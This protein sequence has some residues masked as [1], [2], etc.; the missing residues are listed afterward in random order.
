MSDKP[1]CMFLFSNSG[2]NSIFSEQMRERLSSVVDIQRVINA[3][4]KP[5]LEGVEIC[6]SWDDSPAVVSPVNKLDLII[7][8]GLTPNNVFPTLD[9]PTAWSN[10]PG[11]MDRPGPRSWDNAGLQRFSGGHWKT[12]TAISVSTNGPRLAVLS[13]PLERAIAEKLLAVV[14]MT[15]CSEDF[16]KR[17]ANLGDGTPSVL[18]TIN[19]DFHDIN[20]GIVG[21]SGPVVALCRLLRS[22]EIGLLIHDPDI[23]S[24]AAREMGALVMPN[25]RELAREADVL[26]LLPYKNTERPNP[27]IELWSGLSAESPVVVLNQ[28]LVNKSAFSEFKGNAIVGIDESNE[29]NL[30]EMSNVLYMPG[31]DGILSN[32]LNR[33]GRQIVDV[34]HH[35][36]SI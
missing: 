23:T 24:N 20:V 12:T 28:S 21:W 8:C 15:T 1:Q 4:A 32:S 17:Q 25:I 11:L 29:P 30:S 22:Y 18:A 35:Y 34:I 27:G 2:V 31:M 26:I 5:N 36:V 13:E 3:D 10:Q 14:V 7:H 16:G 9:V 6:V 33:V 19:Q